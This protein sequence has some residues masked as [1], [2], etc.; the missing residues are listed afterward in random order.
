[1]G[2]S[3]KKFDEN[4]FINYFDQN[5]YSLSPIEG[6]YNV[7]LKVSKPLVFCNEC[8]YSNF[9][10]EKFDKVAVINRS[11]QYDIYS[12]VKG[13][14]IGHIENFKLKE[15]Y[16]STEF[17]IV[18]DSKN[19]PRSSFTAN[20]FLNTISYY[21]LFKIE[22]SYNIFEPQYAKLIKLKCSSQ[23]SET[24]TKFCLET[25]VDI[26][27]R[28]VFPSDEYKPKPI[29]YSGTGFLINNSGYLLTNYHVVKKPDFLTGSVIEE[30][31]IRNEVEP[32]FT[33]AELVCFDEER[34]IA[35]LKIL[36]M[37]RYL[38]KFYPLSINPSLQELGT[39]IST[40]GYPFG[41]LTGT[42]VK[43][44]KGYI[45]SEKGLRNSIFEY[46]MDL[47]INPG[48]SGGPLLDNRNNVVAIVNAR[49]NEDAV[50]AQVENISYSIKSKYL[51]EFLKIN[52]INYLI[53]S[54]SKEGDSISNIKKGVFMIQSSFR[55]L[56]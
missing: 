10:V 34:D 3:Q 9:E 47:G 30:F 31:W 39:S 35:V 44:T 36:N 49:L 20:Y 40:I 32:I 51:I 53:P 22:D 15:S 48:N 16:K 27:F 18:I 19:Y 55:K 24:Q 6:I 23:L 45:S 8:E 28:K 26:S 13:V 52:K 21:S 29:Q 5:Y 1:M 25:G 37:N 33:K 38:T 43:Y 42:S 14:W 7:D 50:G 54:N 12:L 56:Y 11:G 46:T 4:Y 2:H 41:D 17:T